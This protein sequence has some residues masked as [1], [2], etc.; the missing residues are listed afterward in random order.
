MVGDW[1]FLGAEDVR[2]HSGLGIAGGGDPLLRTFEGLFGDFAE[3]L[4]PYP[5]FGRRGVAGMA[6]FSRLNRV[7]SNVSGVEAGQH[8]W[9]AAKLASLHADV[10][11]S[12]HVPVFFRVSCRRARTA[13]RPSLAQELVHTDEYR[14]CSARVAEGLGALEPLDE[15]YAVMVELA[16]RAARQARAIF[17]PSWVD[18]AC[19]PCRSLHAGLHSREGGAYGGS[20]T[21][22][23]DTANRQSVA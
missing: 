20:R 11:A 3:L 19:S 6:V 21:G 22:S 14:A 2:V 4:Q 10:R 15:R 8:F 7:C 13:R 12:D 1:N 5:T 9:S 16:H 23:C 18:A 17:V